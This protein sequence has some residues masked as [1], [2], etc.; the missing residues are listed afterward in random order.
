LNRDEKILRKGCN[1]AR[2]LSLGRVWKE[3][4]ADPEKKAGPGTPQTYI[5]QEIEGS[6]M[7]RKMLLIAV[8]V[9]ACLL[10]LFV[11]DNCSSQA[12]AKGG[13]MGKHGFN[14]NHRGYGRDFRY[15]NRYG[16]GNRNYGF[17]GYE[18]PVYETIAP[19]C[20]TCAPIVAPPVAPVCTTCE[21]VV[22]PAVAPVCTT[23]EPSYVGVEPVYAPNWGY[24]HYRNHKENPGR[25]HPLASHRGT[26]RRG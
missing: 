19:V 16:W 23:C 26:G 7:F 14:Q 3:K 9:T 6:T 2:G 24:R 15:S 10:T 11:T 20:T 5:C 17:Y 25:F 22:A 13:P 4:T 12:F 1:K 8:P 21:P 18:A